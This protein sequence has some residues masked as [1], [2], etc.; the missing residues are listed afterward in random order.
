LQRAQ[1][2]GARPD[3]SV[4]TEN[5]VWAMEGNWEG[6]SRIG[7]G[8]GKPAGRV[9]LGRIQKARPRETLQLKV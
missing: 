1:L 3:A 7:Y 9:E 4:K 5:S 2:S 6:A 8:S